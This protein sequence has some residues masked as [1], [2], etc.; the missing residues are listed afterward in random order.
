VFGVNL[1]GVNVTFK[2]HTKESFPT[3]EG[4]ETANHAYLKSLK[5]YLESNS[6]GLPGSSKSASNVSPQ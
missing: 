3:F 4:Y 5:A 2:P 6:I 1:E